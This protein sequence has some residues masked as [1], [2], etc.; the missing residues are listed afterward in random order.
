MDLSVA[1]DTVDHD[2]LLSVLHN[3]FNITSN[4]LS[5]FNTYLCPRQF[6]VNVESHKSSNKPLD[7]S[8]PKDVVGGLLC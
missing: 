2:I 7:F 8:V 3:Q 6:Y 4:A 5:W 1:F